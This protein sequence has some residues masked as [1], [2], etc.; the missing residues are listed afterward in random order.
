M[1]IL[2]LRPCRRPLTSRPMC[3]LWCVRLFKFAFSMTQVAGN[4]KLM[5]T[6]LDL[7][8][9]VCHFFLDQS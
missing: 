7:I 5:S 2:K 8:T 3:Q 9:D 4:L 6:D 1:Y